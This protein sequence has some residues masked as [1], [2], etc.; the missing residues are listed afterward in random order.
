MVTQL[1]G[2]FFFFST[3]CQGSG[4]AIIFAIFWSVDGL[5]LIYLKTKVQPFKFPACPGHDSYGTEASFPL[6]HDL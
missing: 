5:L 4:K 3:Q 1:L 6:I 2:N